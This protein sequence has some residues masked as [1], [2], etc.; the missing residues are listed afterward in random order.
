MNILQDVLQ[1]HHSAFAALQAAMTTPSTSHDPLLA[2]DYS[3][4]FTLAS[5][6]AALFTKAQRAQL[7]VYGIWAV[8]RNQLLTDDSFLFNKTC[9]TIKKLI[10]ELPVSR[11]E[12]ERGNGLRGGKEEWSE[13][14]R[15][16]WRREALVECLETG[17]Q[18]YK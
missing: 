8:V 12:E 6:H 7:D 17:R 1:P 4:L 15:L 3:K 13:E 9:T 14:E 10:E 16:Y 2:R 18:C 11:T 5:K